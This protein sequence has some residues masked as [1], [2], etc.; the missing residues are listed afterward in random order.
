MSATDPT[1]A[2]LS[3]DREAAKA[4]VRAKVATDKAMPARERIYHLLCA[5]HTHAEAEAMLA[6]VEGN[7]A[8]ELEQLR[9][10]YAEA[11]ATVAQ[12]VLERGERTKVENA[13]RERIAELEAERHST[14]ESLS[15]AAERLRVDRDRIAE[16]EKRPTIDAVAGWL[17]KKAREYPT[18]PE[19]QESVPD[20]IARLASKVMRGAI[21]ATNTVGVP[22]LTVYRA[23]YDSI[24]FGLYTTA[25]AAREHCEAY[26]HQD[27]QLTGRLNW[28]LDEPDEDDSPEELTAGGTPTGYV[29]TPLTVASRYDEEADE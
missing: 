9:V 5:T 15:E 18:A 21:R 27:P 10:R 2:P 26:A 4:R 1:P 19:R 22:P 7:S 20:A 11:A 23:E 24:P 28:V 8:A 12:L 6:E 14:N 3:P 17:R 16:L 13:L 29:V 25:Q